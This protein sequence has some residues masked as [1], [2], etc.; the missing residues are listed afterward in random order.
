MQLEDLRRNFPP[1]VDVPLPLQR[2]LAYQNRV[3]DFYSGSFELYDQGAMAVLYWFDQDKLAANQFAIFGHQKDGSLYG[4]WLYN[5]RLSEHAPIVFL[6]SEGEGNVVLANTF[7]EFLALLALGED[8]LGFAVTKPEYDTGRTIDQQLFEFGEWLV[9]EF[10]IEAPSDSN[11]IVQAA[12]SAHPDLDQWI[13]Q[14]ADKRYG[15]N[16]HTNLSPS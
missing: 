14:W 16:E 5:D 12:K 15:S 1:D 4:Y 2:L 8:E 9:K 6:G 13:A 3:H 7:E 11:L 10:R